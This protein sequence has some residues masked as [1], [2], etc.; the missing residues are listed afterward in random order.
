M[1]GVI[2]AVCEGKKEMEIQADALSDCQM[3]DRCASSGKVTSKVG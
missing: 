1:L 2:A 3:E